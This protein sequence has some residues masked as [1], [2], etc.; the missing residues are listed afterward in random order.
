MMER[1]PFGAIPPSALFV[2]LSPDALPGEHRE[3]LTELARLLPHLNWRAHVY[4]IDDDPSGHTERACRVIDTVADYV[5]TQPLSTVCVHPLLWMDAFGQGE[6][7]N[8]QRMLGLVAEFQQEAYRHQ[9]EMRLFIL[10]IIQASSDLSPGTIVAGAEFFR[11]RL[12]KP[13]LYFRGESPLDPETVVEKELRVYVDRQPGPSREGVMRQL[14]MN[15]IFDGVLERMEGAPDALLDPCEQH[16]IID[17]GGGLLFSC[18]GEWERGRPTCLLG[19]VDDV[20][21]VTK[22]LSATESC[23][24]C[25]SRQCLEMT[26]NL[27]ANGR[28]EEGRQVCLNL[29]LA[30]VGRGRHADA[31]LHATAAYELGWNDADRAAALLHAG[32]CHMQMMD[33]DRAERELVEG[34]ELATDPGVFSYHLGRL[35]FAQQDYIRAIGLFEEA[36]N[37]GSPDVMRDDLHFNLAV[38]WINLE[39]Y[40]AAIRNLDHIARESTAVR[41]YRGVCALAQGSAGH[42]LA[43]FRSALELGPGP[44][45]L[46]RVYFYIATCLKELGRFDEAISALAEAIDADSEEYLNYNLLGFCYY[47]TGRY[48]KAIEALYKAVALNPASAIDYASIGSNLRELGRLEDAIAMYSMALSLDPDLAFARE[49]VR[50]LRRKLDGAD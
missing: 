50:K 31:A 21:A 46:S 14:G 33:L 36:L 6:I 48:E 32:L 49:N 22:M 12:A 43:A 17:E 35:K 34:A 9:N 29:S 20:G 19:R 40:E 16:L 15:H 3:F 2:R 25:V 24:E 30:L 45:D 38:S 4:V 10:P 5:R 37:E 47:Q 8:W 7:E 41:F 13:S 11:T 39:D 42:A 27:E 23:E 26:V 1:T 28:R 18:F 44:E